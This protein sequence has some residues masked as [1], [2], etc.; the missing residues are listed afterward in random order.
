[1][2]GRAAQLSQA[3]IACRVFKRPDRLRSRARPDRP[4]PGGAPAALARA[5]LPALGQRGPSSDRSAPGRLCPRLALGDAG[6]AGPSGARRPSRVRRRTGTTGPR[7]WSR[8]SKPPRRS[9][10]GP[11]P[12]GARDRARPL[13]GRA[14]RPRRTAGR[15]RTGTP[16]GPP[17][18]SRRLRAR[19]GASRVVD[20]AA[21][22]E[23]ACLA[24]PGGVRCAGLGGRLPG[25]PVHAATG[26]RLRRDRT[27]RSSRRASRPSTGVGAR[28]RWLRSYRAPAAR[29][30]SDPASA[31]LRS[32]QLLLQPR[33][34]RSY[35]PSA[36]ARRWRRAVSSA[37]GRACLGVGAQLARLYARE[38]RLRG[39]RRSATP[40]EE[41]DAPRGTRRGA[42]VEPTSLP[43]GAGGARARRCS[44]QGELGAG[45]GRGGDA[46][47]ALCPEP[48]SPTS[49]A[50]GWVLSA[51]S[52]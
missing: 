34:R 1:M 9:E 23:R 10:R 13:P 36:P 39:R 2:A 51:S 22:G 33:R 48:R 8:A 35:D 7:S 18:A 49:N 12:R 52:G 41:A 27:R 40:I 20:G 32:Y 46:R 44:S 29:R 3:S 14:R 24:R 47:H 5:L 4:H 31:L 26:A 17:A 6:R 11:P 16:A 19:R 15:R 42:R 37:A 38:P 43:A 30:S 45:P 25:G 50:L 21:A 28:H